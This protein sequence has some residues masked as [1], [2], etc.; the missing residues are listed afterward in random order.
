MIITVTTSDMRTLVDLEISELE[1]QIMGDKII[2]NKQIKY[3]YITL[4]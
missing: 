4:N 2:S 3:F 1:V